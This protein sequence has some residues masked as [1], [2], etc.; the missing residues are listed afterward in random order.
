MKEA[1]MEI[2]IYEGSPVAGKTVEQVKKEF[3][4]NILKATR[5]K[6]SR[7][8]STSLILDE[9]DYIY[10]VGEPEK[11]LEFIR[12]AGGRLHTLSTKPR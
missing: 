9:A 7:N 12:F 3:D 8:P 6:E 10:F 1:K 5:G 2:R 4:I 11:C